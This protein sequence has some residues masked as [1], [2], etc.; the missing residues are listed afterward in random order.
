MEISKTAKIEKAMSSDVTRLNVSTASLCKGPDGKPAL[1]ATDGHVLA[2]CP[3]EADESEFGL[4][5]KEAL[6]HGRKLAKG[7][8]PVRFTANSGFGFDDGSTLPRPTAA[9]LGDFPSWQQV[10]PEAAPEISIGIN[11]KLLLDLAHAIDS[12]KGVVLEIK[13]GSSPISV[14]P[15]GDANENR[16]VIMPMRVK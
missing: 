6:I 7:S 1:V 11:P 14:R 4:V 3:V 5:T 10:I 13:D 8:A 9:D 2:I 12:S 16:G 15:F